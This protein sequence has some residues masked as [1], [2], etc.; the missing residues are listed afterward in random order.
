MNGVLAAKATGY[1]TGYV[2]FVLSAEASAA[3]QPGA[4]TLA[5]HCK[6]TTGGQ[7]IDAGIVEVIEVSEK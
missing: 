6:Q 3:L 2:P 5:I 4:N 7:Y 1:T